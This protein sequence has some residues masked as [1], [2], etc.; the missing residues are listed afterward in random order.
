[1]VLYMHNDEHGFKRNVHYNNAS[2]AIRIHHSLATKATDYVKKNHV[3]RLQ[4]A[5]MAQYLIQTRWA[6]VMFVIIDV[7]YS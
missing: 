1:M 7:V 4:T 6:Y 3:F 2:N 5:D